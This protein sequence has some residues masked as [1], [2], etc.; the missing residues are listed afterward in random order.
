MSAGHSSPVFAFYIPIAVRSNNSRPSDEH[1]RQMMGRKR[2]LKW[3]F[4]ILSAL[5]YS[6]IIPQLFVPCIFSDEFGEGRKPERKPVEKAPG[7]EGHRRTNWKCFY[8]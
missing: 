6:F 5:P 2:N 7:P 3:R 4:S 8:L 1:G